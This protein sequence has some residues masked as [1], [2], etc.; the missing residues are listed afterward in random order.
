MMTNRLRVLSAGLL[1][2][3]VTLISGTTRAAD[4]SEAEQVLSALVEA[5]RI[6][7][8]E[9]LNDFDRLSLRRSQ[10]DDLLDGLYQELD[11]AIKQSERGSVDSITRL[12]EQIEALEDVRRGALLSLRGM[13]DRIEESRRRLQLLE[14]QVE[15]LAS[16]D[17]TERGRLSGEW[18]VTLLPHG[19]GGTFSLT[20]SGTL[21]SGSYNLEGGFDG[22]LQGTLVNRKVFLVRIDS[23]RGRTME[24]EG[25][26][27]PDGRQIRG[28]WLDYN[29]SRGEE[30]RGDWS[31]RR[32]VA[33]D[34]DR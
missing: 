6:R 30:A 19:Q 2:V 20:Q 21:I 15:A 8:L 13:L 24:F 22:S 12:R 26:L 16:K 3:M 5:E 7:L 32:T 4:G 33:A 1:L 17:K 28:N 31:A 23:K 34:D 25:Y 29:L 27:S 10:T 18:T 14:D 11:G 9:T